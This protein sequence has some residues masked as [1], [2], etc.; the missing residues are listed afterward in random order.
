MG[1]AMNN[2]TAWLLSYLVNA[3][4][5]VPLI[6]AAAW[7]AAWMVR[8]CGPAVQHR[9]WVSAVMLEALLPGC[10]VQHWRWLQGLLWHGRPADVASRGQVTV[11]MGPGTGL[12]SLHLPAG[13]L[14]WIAAGYVTVTIYSAARLGWR[15]F[16]TGELRREAMPAAMTIEAARCWDQCCEAFQVRD[17]EMRVSAAIAGP[18]TL[19][20]WDRLVVMPVMMLETL[21]G[22][23]LHTAMAHEFAHM[24]RRDFGK[25]L[26]YEALC[27]T[28]WF[29]PMYWL[30]REQLIET[31]EETC[32]AMA[33]EVVAGRERYARSL[34]RL[35]ALFVEGRS[36]SATH[37]IGIFDANQFERRLVKLMRHDV[38]TSGLRRL[39][40]IAGCGVL[41]LGTCVSAL[42]LRTELTVAGGGGVETT[43]RA[44]DGT[45]KVPANV[46][47]SQVISK[48]VP[49]YPAEAKQAGIEGAVVLHAVIGTNGTVENLTVVSGPEELQHSALDA[50]SQWLYKPYL[51][52]GDPVEVETTI[53]VNYSLAR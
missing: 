41:G 24:Q 18:V 23:D 43:G 14:T 44:P 30:T 53:T 34:L 2:V 37:A 1:D 22:E 52:N 8:R 49:V 15:C 48:V 21:S 51:L 20:V 6:F 36:L 7:M 16:R 28:I 19:G 50:V 35:A 13:L 39:A 40:L 47:A 11:V 29:H 42:A 17:S 5:Q 3:V 12:A 46:M 33:A 25:H 4:W 26:L 45:L 10:T 32:D 38:R 27:V 9:V 31:R